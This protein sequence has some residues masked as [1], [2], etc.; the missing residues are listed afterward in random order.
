LVAVGLSLDRST[1]LQYERGTVG[2]PDPVVLW[3][4]GWLYHVTVDD[5]I[6][7]LVRDRTGRAAPRREMPIEL[8]VDQRRLVDSFADLSD[9]SR[10]VALGILEV[11]AAQPAGERPA[12]PTPK[13]FK[14]IKT[15]HTR[16]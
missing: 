7:D 6:A 2:S 11:L 16:V 8:D 12:S 10:R 4:L 1:L 5:L 9:E 15:K 14:T 3:G 13:K